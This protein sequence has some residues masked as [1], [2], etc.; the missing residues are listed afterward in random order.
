MPASPSSGKHCR[1][2]QLPLFPPIVD[3]SFDLLPAL[4]EQGD[5]QY[6]G[7]SARSALNA[8]A[9]TG[10]RFWSANPYVGCAFGCTYCYARY[11]HRYAIRRGLDAERLDDGLAASVQEMPHWLAFE[12]RILVKRNLPDVLAR[13]L[14]YGS[15]RYAGLA[16]ARRSSS[17]RRRIRTSPRSD[18]SG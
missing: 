10:M 15:D 17:A 1:S 14:R 9:A 18:A 3:Q 6:F 4:G 5:I 2:R 11:A 16:R 13:A 7:T 8:P 12:R